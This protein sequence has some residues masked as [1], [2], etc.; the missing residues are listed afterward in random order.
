[1]DAFTAALDRCASAG[2]IRKWNDFFNGTSSGLQSTALRW[3]CRNICW[4]VWL[5]G[6]GLGWLVLVNA[7]KIAVRLDG[8][9]AAV[10]PP[11]FRIIIRLENASAPLTHN[12]HA[13]PYAILPQPLKKAVRI[14]ITSAGGNQPD[15]RR[16]NP[17]KRDD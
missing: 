16:P 9:K 7:H 10:D 11:G 6:F 5:V 4:L 14:A 8:R 3:S 17:W 1:M 12:R 13:S 15:S 2:S